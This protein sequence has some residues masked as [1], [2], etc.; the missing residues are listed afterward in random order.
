MR[1]FIRICTTQL[2]SRPVSRFLGIACF[3]LCTQSA[4]S[5]QV[6][7]KDLLTYMSTPPAQ[8]DQYM[9]HNNFICYKSE[10]GLTG[11]TCLFAY[12]GNTLLNRPTV[13]SSVI[14]YVR[15]SRS[16]IL[17]YQVHSKEQCEELQNELIRLGYT[18]DPTATKRLT[19]TQNN[20]VVT[21]QKTDTNNGISGNYSGYTLSLVRRWY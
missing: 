6:K 2:R 16:D 11:W 4:F 12:S 9:F 20:T 21:C 5:Q 18:I 13:A 15:T 1:L 17:L 19:Y 14:Q 10:G 8:F 3:L 7:M